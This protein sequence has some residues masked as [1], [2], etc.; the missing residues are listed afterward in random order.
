MKGAPGL[1]FAIGLGIVA[2]FCNWLYLANKGKQLEMVSFIAIAEDVKIRAG[3]P[4]GI[5][6]YRRDD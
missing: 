2:A 5:P 6:G 1:L 4:V 3:D